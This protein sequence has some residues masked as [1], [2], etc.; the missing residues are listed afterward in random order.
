MKVAKAPPVVE[1]QTVEPKGAEAAAPDTRIHQVVIPGLEDVAEAPLTVVS[2]ASRP[3]EPVLPLVTEA[4]VNQPG[5]AATRETY[6]ERRDRLVSAMREKAARMIRE[7]D[8]RG[9]RRAA[10]RVALGALGQTI[11]LREA[12]FRVGASARLPRR[13]GHRS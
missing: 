6:A 5:S 8:S 3:D 4:A 13:G 1:A 9:S 2:P 11:P 10:G 7:D 12:Q